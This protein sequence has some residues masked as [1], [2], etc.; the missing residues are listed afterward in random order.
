M[1]KLHFLLYHFPRLV[2]SVK[3][4]CPV[5]LS[6]GYTQTRTVRMRREA[7]SVR[8]WNLVRDRDQSTLQT[9]CVLKPEVFASCEQCDR[10]GNIAVH[11]IQC[12][13]RRHLGSE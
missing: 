12:S 2:R 3:A 13:H 4:V 11:P 7:E 9:A 8:I 6:R 1:L 5:T 10:L